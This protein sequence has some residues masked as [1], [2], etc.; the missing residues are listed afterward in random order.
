M[1][2]RVLVRRPALACVTLAVALA[3]CTAGTARRTDIP[4]LYYYDLGDSW[5]T[6]KRRV[7]LYAC[8]SGTKVCTGPASYLDVTFHCGCE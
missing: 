1:S 4:A 8:R 3:G 7:D 6:R 5:T 2:Y